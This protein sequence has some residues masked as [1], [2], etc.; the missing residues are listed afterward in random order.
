MPGL[1][2]TAVAS[3]ALFGQLHPRTG[4]VIPP[5]VGGQISN[6]LIS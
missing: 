1:F 6:H 2:R 5:A 3:D 4:K